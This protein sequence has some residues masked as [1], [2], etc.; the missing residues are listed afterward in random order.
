MTDRSYNDPKLNQA[1]RRH[2]LLDRWGNP[3]DVANAVAFLCDSSSNYITG[4]NLPVDGGWSA[5]GLI[6]DF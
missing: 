1:R 3:E 6:E 2:T 4:I 5:C